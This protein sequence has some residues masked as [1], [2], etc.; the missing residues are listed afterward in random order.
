[1]GG[2]ARR[3]LVANR[4]HGRDSELCP[5]MLLSPRPALRM[6]PCSTPVP[7]GQAV[8]AQPCRVFVAALQEVGMHACPMAFPACLSPFEIP[9]RDVVLG[10]SQEKVIRIDASGH[11]AAMQDPQPSR[12]LTAMQKPGC[13]MG[14]HSLPAH[15]E[16]AVGIAMTHPQPAARHRFVHV[17]AFESLRRRHHSVPPAG[18]GPFAPPTASRTWLARSRRSPANPP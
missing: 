11:I 14:S 16:Q 12:D 15:C 5:Y 8:R 7:S 6:P 9:V 18:S 10:T 3:V 13:A 2:N 17:A 1:M 4:G